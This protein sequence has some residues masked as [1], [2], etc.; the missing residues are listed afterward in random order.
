VAD[1]ALQL[2]ISKHLRLGDFLTTPDTPTD[3]MPGFAALD[4]RTSDDFAPLAGLDLPAGPYLAAGIETGAEYLSVTPEDALRDILARGRSPVTVEEGIAVVTHLPHL[5]GRNA[6]FSLP[7]SRG[8]DQ[9]VPA[10]WI[11]G[12]RPRLGWCWD[13]NPHTWLGSASCAFRI[14]AG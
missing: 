3:G 13:R 10:I 6:C 9:R 5:L 14:G 1:A 12:G 8:S 7:G 11:S 4:P 2:P